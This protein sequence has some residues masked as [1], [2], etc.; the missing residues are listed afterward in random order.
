[1]ILTPDKQQDAKKVIDEILGNGPDE[2]DFISKVAT[3]DGFEDENEK[4]VN[5]FTTTSAWGTTFTSPAP[6]SYQKSKNTQDAS[7]QQETNNLENTTNS[8]E[9]EKSNNLE[10]L[11]TNDLHQPLEKSDVAIEDVIENAQE[12]TLEQNTPIQER[13]TNISENNLDNS[14]LQDLPLTAN[15]TEAVNDFA[16]QVSKSDQN[17]NQSE[18]HHTF[19]WESGGT[20]TIENEKQIIINKPA[21][22]DNI[23][24]ASFKSVLSEFEK[25]LSKEE[26][27]AINADKTKVGIEFNSQDLHT[28]FAPLYELSDL[29]L[30]NYITNFNSI[31]TDNK[32]QWMREDKNGQLVFQDRIIL[33]ESI[34]KANASKQSSSD[35]ASPLRQVSAEEFRTAITEHLIT[36]LF[37]K[38]TKNADGEII[39][40][41]ERNVSTNFQHIWHWDKNGHKSVNLTVWI[42]QNNEIALHSNEQKDKPNGEFTRRFNLEIFARPDVK[43]HKGKKRLDKSRDKLAELVDFIAK[44]NLE[45]K[46]VPLYHQKLQDYLHNRKNRFEASELATITSHFHSQRQNL[47]TELKKA[48]QNAIEAQDKVNAIAKNIDN[49]EQDLQKKRQQNQQIYQEFRQEHEK[50]KIEKQLA[51]EEIAKMRGNKSPQEYEAHLARELTTNLNLTN[52]KF[53]D[54]IER[55][56]SDNQH[57]IENFNLEQQQ[58]IE[59]ASQKL[60]RLKQSLSKP[61]IAERFLKIAGRPIVLFPIS[62]MFGLQV[63][64]G[65]LAFYYLAKII[66]SKAYG[67]KLSTLEKERD[68]LV[69]ERSEKLKQIETGKAK[70]IEIFQNQELDEKQKLKDAY[71]LKKGRLEELVKKLDNYQSE[72]DASIATRDKKIAKIQQEIDNTKQK[73]NA[74][75]KEHKAQISN[76]E[77]LS[78]TL[79]T[80]Q[81]EYNTI[82]A[83]IGESIVQERQDIKGAI[84]NY[85]SNQ[86]QHSY[87]ERSLQQY[88]EKARYFGDTSQ[89]SFRVDNFNEN[90]N[91]ETTRQSQLQGRTKSIPQ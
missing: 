5:N 64:M 86:A 10:Q 1:M 72:L 40:D 58:K 50:R 54:K 66:K 20:N 45:A 32:K 11:N 38:P 4:Q 49:L 23:Q 18:I 89:S 34:I 53:A 29:T 41:Q 78:Q 81:D 15:A 69:K 57:Q 2:A 19:D 91:K 59:A 85:Y 48:N 80:R 33:N 56:T 87:N 52:D 84:N 31:N 16:P 35:F 27:D 37:L 14:Q 25:S 8:L 74:A 39:F 7:A 3:E 83:K 6:P 43:K 67:S 71:N 42:N 51:T 17:T 79:A 76:Y 68:N 44:K 75:S 73:I 55:F 47:D 61:T 46:Q 9:Q 88:N 13:S 65:I 30:Y 77:T 90:A 60:E 12:Q 82:L 62:M 28:L 22:L 70:Q 24:D 26:I 21:Y 36:H 63:G